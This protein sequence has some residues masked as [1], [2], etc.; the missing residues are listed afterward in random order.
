MLLFLKGGMFDDRHQYE[1]NTRFCGAELNRGEPS[2]DDGGGSP[3]Y[4]KYLINFNFKN[5]YRKRFG[6]YLFFFCD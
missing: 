5:D 1:K 2:P 6:K 4:S 3:S